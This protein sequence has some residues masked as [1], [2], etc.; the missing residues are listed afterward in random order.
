MKTVA[1]DHESTLDDSEFKECMEKYLDL[2]SRCCRG[3]FGATPQYW[4]LYQRMIDL[5]HQLHYSV[6]INDFWLRLHS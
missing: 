4:M 5:I 2:R 6:N 1:D 3:E